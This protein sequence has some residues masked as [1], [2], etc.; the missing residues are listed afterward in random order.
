MRFWDSSALVPLLVAEST[1]A[2]A[3]AAFETDPDVIAWWA[4]LVECTSA[5]AR[6]ERDG[7][8]TSASLTEAVR[9]LASLRDA[10]AEVQPTDRVRSTALR[11]LRTHPLRAGDALQLAAAIAAA[12]DH[13]ASLPFVALDERLAQAAEREGFVVVHPGQD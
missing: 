12:E 2:W 3:T 4:S 8:L 13:P 11:L 10:W 7:L 6:L 9:R 5:L 1:S